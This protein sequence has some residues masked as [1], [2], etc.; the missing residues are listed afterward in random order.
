VP[1]RLQLA[2]RRR[3]CPALEAAEGTRIPV[4]Y[5]N[6]AEQMNPDPTLDVVG[7]SNVEAR[8]RRHYLFD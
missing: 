4:A 2:D 7:R 5:D 8:F 6:S 1:K 3:V